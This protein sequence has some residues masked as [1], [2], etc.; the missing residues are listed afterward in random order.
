MVSKS[1]ESNFVSL[2]GGQYARLSYGRIRHLSIQRGNDDRRPH[3]DTDQQPKKKM[4]KAG[5]DVKHVRSLSMFQH[6]G[7]RLLSI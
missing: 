5:M 7:Q 3:Q 6:Q 2:L 1:L 4:I